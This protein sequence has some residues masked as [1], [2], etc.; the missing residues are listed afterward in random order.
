MQTASRQT[1]LQRKSSRQV[2]VNKVIAR[3]RRSEVSHRSYKGIDVRLFSCL[4]L[5]AKLI[6]L[7]ITYFVSGSADQNMT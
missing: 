5:R 3:S 4:R 6:V 1:L 7:F 2:F